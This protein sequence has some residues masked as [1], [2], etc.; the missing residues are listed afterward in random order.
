MPHDR[1]REELSY[2]PTAV[3]NGIRVHGLLERAK[4]IIVD[5]EYM[6]GKITQ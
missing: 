6:L 2:H 1:G 5:G 4:L 3:H